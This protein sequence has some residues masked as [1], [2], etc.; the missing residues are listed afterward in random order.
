MM[1]VMMMIIICF[2]GNGKW[3]FWCQRKHCLLVLGAIGLPV[4]GQEVFDQEDGIEFEQM[5]PETFH[6]SCFLFSCQLLSLSEL[7]FRNAISQDIGSGTAGERIEMARTA[8]GKQSFWSVLPLMNGPPTAHSGKLLFV[9]L[10]S[11][12]Q[13]RLA[14]KAAIC[15]PIHFTADSFSLTI[16]GFLFLRIEKRFPARP[17]IFLTL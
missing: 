17:M 8:L 13:Q 1:M 2:S 4:N 5:G 14:N 16:L 6:I 10:S 12:W 9:L 3:M 11:F 15:F 7:S